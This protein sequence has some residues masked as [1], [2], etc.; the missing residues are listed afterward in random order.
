MKKTE[1]KMP[2]EVYS[3]VVGYFRP[4]NQWNKGKQE[5]FRE[6]KEISLTSLHNFIFS[7]DLA[8]KVY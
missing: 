5:E 4:V 6:R 8:Q 7:A 3:R 1:L 2:V